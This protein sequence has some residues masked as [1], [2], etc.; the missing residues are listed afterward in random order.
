M[1][2]A[3]HSGSTFSLQLIG[4]FSVNDQIDDKERK[5]FAKVNGASVLFSVAREHLRVLTSAGPYPAIY[6]PA[7]SFVDLLQDT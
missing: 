2:S 1:G 5:D 7:V 4:L 6:L 3:G